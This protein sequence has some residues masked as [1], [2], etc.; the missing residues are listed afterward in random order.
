MMGRPPHLE[1]V[2]HEPSKC[3][4]RAMPSTHRADSAPD[5]APWSPQPRYGP[6]LRSR[7]W[8]TVNLILAEPNFLVLKKII[9]CLLE[10]L[11]C[12]N[13]REVFVCDCFVTSVR[14]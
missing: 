13:L 4:K 8:F 5:R 7:Y 12:S 6:P 11:P 2:A 1:K 3:S 9:L 10:T 14:V